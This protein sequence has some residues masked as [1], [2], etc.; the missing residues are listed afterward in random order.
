MPSS[1]LLLLF[2]LVSAAVLFYSLMFFA[3]SLLR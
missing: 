3:F 1:F 2:H